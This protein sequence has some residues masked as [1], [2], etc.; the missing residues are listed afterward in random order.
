MALLGKFAK[1]AAQVAGKAAIAAA[2]AAKVG[3]EVAVGAAIGGAAIVSSAAANAQ[4]EVNNRRYRP[5]FLEEYEDEAFDRP[6]LIIISDEDERKGVEACAGAVGWMRR[7]LSPEVM[8]L[9]EEFLP[10]SG[11][12]FYPRPVCDAAYCIDPFDSSR[13][14]ELGQFLE[15][16]R[17]DQMTELKQIA[18]M[19]GAKKCRLEYVEEVKTSVET[20]G[21]FGRNIKIPVP[22]IPKITASAGVD[23]SGSFSRDT[24]SSNSILF[25]QI[26]E[27]G[28]EPS[29]PTLKWYKDDNEIRN[30]IE[31]RL[32]AERN[33][34]KSYRVE[35]SS[36]AS[37]CM[38]ASQ[39]AKID[40]SL[41]KAGVKGSFS[42]SGQYETE[43]RKKMKFE[44]TF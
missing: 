44:V 11:L 25:E 22:E 5:L 21:K 23:Q 34:T 36:F 32:N 35:V 41:G 3:A 33:M 15:V 30:L 18:H 19:L 4:N 9:Y 1:G 37:M 43:A 7:D 40:S 16:A 17:R 39:A 31:T 2:G 12:S 38:S 28:A 10:K 26:Y 20:N 14:I 6:K 13:Y 29:E 42:L 27:G 24:F 8:H